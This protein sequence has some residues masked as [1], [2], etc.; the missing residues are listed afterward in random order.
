MADVHSPEP[1]GRVRRALFVLLTT[2]LAAWFATSPA[3]AQES[4]EGAWFAFAGQGRLPDASSDQRLRWWFD[5]HARFFEGSDGFET[6]ILRPGLGYDLN[7]DTTAWMGYAWIRNDPPAG[8][9]DEH[10][11]WQQLTWGKRYD[12]GI[13]FSRTRLEQRFDERGSDVGWR[14]RQFVRWTRPVAS[15][16]RLGWRV[17]DEAFLD[18]NDTDWGQDV[19]L[20]QNR[21]FSGLGWTLDRSGRHTLEVGY[22]NQYLARDGADD[23]SNHILAVTL[24]A[25]Y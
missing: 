11:I 22:L 23:A 2:V 9:F 19:G 8:G 12:W 13:P 21:A 3:P 16:S 1:A 4:D 5:A 6:G 20:N 15:G 7:P 18:L 24:L 17:W 14:L 25:N 10:R